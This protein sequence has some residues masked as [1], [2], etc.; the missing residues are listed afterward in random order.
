MG[1][2]DTQTIGLDAAHVHSHGDAPVSSV[3]PIGAPRVLKDPVVLSP[4]NQENGVP[5]YK[6]G[7]LLLVIDRGRVIGP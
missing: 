2:K 6:H 3:S 4:P 7:P 1:G 5:R